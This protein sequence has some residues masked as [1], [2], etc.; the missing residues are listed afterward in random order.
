MSLSKLHLKALLL[1]LT[2]NLVFGFCMASYC[3]SG[4]IILPS[5]SLDFSLMQGGSRNQLI[6][7]FPPD[8]HVWDTPGDQPQPPKE[9]AGAPLELLAALPDVSIRRLCAS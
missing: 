1:M 3:F 8:C 2:N 7:D 5:A 6:F 4:S 9:G